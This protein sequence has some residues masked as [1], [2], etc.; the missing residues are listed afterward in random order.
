MDNNNNLPERKTDHIR[1]NLENDVISGLITGL[2]GY[3]FVHQALPEMDL[4]QVSLQTS[5]FGKTLGA[6]FLIS[7]MT[8][9]TDQAL[10]LNRRLAAAAQE[11]GFAMGVG[12]QRAAI[13]DTWTG[14]QFPVAGCCT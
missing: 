10:H 13:E 7:S 6:P 8:G 1:I 11:F 12:S 3:Q 4:T 2:D 5:L 9:G 14:V